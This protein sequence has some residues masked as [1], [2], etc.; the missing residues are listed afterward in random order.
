MTNLKGLIGTQI[1]VIR[2]AKGLPQQDVAD[3]VA[4]NTDQRVLA[5]HAFLKSKPG[6]KTLL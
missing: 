1:K 5:N 2:K 6:S 4:E 3:R